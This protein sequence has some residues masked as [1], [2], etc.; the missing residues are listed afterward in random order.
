MKKSLALILSLLLLLNCFALTASSQQASKKSADKWRGFEEFVARRMAQDKIPGLTIG[1]VRGDE[2]W[3]KGFGYADVENKVPATA[4]SAYRLASVTKTMTGAAI[5][6]LAERGKLSLD[7]EIQTYVPYYPKQKWPV[8]VRQL[9]V[10]LGGGQTGS[11]IGPEYVTPREVV[12]RISKYPIQNEPGVKFDYQ[13]SGYNLLGA[14]I[15]E[16]SGKSFGEY[17]KE[18]IWTPLGMK[19]T[20]MDSVRELIPNR[21]RG[22]ELVNGEIRNAPFLDV[23]SRFGG[24]G[25]IGTVP[26]MLRWA[27]GIERAG[28]L[29]QSSLDLMFT[30][31]ANKSGHYVG[32]NEGEW[33]YT[34]GWQ[35]FPVNGRYVFYNDG[36]QTGTN[37]MALRV[38]SLKL[39]IAFACN[40]QEI[41]RMPYVKRLY[42]LVTGEPWDIN[43]SLKDRLDRSLYKGMSE[44]FNYGSLYLDQHARPVTTDTTELAKSFA[45]FNR[46]V[47]RAALQSDFDKTAAAINDGRHP[48]A[49]LAFLKVGSY[50]LMKLREKYGAARAESYH[51]TGAI[52]FFADYVELCKAQGCP[53]E[54]KLNEPFEQLIV[55][56]NRDWTRTWNDYVRRLTFTPDSNL[57]SISERLKKDF[58]GAQI[59]PNLL[60]QL[61]EARQSEEA[62]KD[63]PRA[64]QVAQL[65]AELYPE[66]DT[67]N[68]YYAIDLIMLGRKDEARAAL[69]KG[70][71]INANG[72][73][74]ARVMSQI[75]RALA[76]INRTDASIAWLLISAE[77]YPKDAAIY[78]T[79]GDIYLKQQQ[80]QQAIEAFRKAIAIDPDF[81]HAKEMLKKL[82]E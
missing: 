59:Y 72:I 47:S 27:S 10:H 50:M 3:V 53:P 69:K 68:V 51:T 22:Y 18:N 48:A 11:G 42:E 54:L 52:P 23:S 12:A 35:V 4:E 30:P 46:T 63:L 2:T 79:L 24:G 64:L 20:R 55:S 40:L 71:S 73:A 82:V 21:V 66:S 28:I 67:A 65:A 57:S 60:G 81:A 33:Y 29:S 70:A 41:D 31:V 1:F 25:A 6:Q 78:D 45:Y 17:L 38:P 49:D 74:S 44:T 32:I 56:W 62:R 75:A 26:D 58:A 9:L 76:A 13:T 8:T 39:A 34:L 61:L 77:L 80:K 7:G 5:V 15:E 16:V 36:G 43:V 14:A 19:D 37:T